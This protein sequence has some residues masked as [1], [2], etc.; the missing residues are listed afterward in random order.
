MRTRETVDD[1]VLVNGYWYERA[2]V[3]RLR[4]EEALLTGEEVDDDPE[5]DAILKEVWEKEEE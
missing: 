5:L 2:Y 3:E 1:Y 4:D